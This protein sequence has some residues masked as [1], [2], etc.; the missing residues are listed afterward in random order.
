[1]VRD[2]REELETLIQRTDD[3]INSDVMAGMEAR[4][5]ASYIDA[6]TETRTAH[7]QKVLDI[8]DPA[9]GGV[10]TLAFAVEALK[11]KVIA[12]LVITAAQLAAAAA[13]AIVTGG[14]SAAANVAIIAA[15]KKFLEFA[16]NVIIDQ[17]V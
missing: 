3:R 17:A 1:M 5:S 6:W 9:A 14:L 11:Q 15:R 4:V 8:L 2:F 7:M 16:T 13:T 12:E 10:D